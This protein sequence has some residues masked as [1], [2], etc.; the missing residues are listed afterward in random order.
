MSDIKF[1]DLDVFTRH[2]IIAAL[3][4]TNDE[5]TPSGGEPMDANYSP[6]DIA[7]ETL[8]KI[9][10]DCERFQKDN[11]ELLEAAYADG[12]LPVN[13]SGERE[14]GAASAGHDFWLTRS[15]HGA[16]F[17]DGDWDSVEDNG[18]EYGDRLT[19]ASKQFKEV[20]LYVGDDGQIHS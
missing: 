12:S 4:S 13:G 18:P 3:W 20:Y 1:A 6:E 11:R 2:Y 9:R 16:G 15:G 8:L 17:W 10:E 14:G 5:S 19:E 7:Q